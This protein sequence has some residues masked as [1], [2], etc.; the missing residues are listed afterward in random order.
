[1]SPKEIASGVFHLPVGIANVYFVG[2]SGGPWVLVDTAVPGRARQIRDAA[3]SVYGLEG[4]PESIVLTHGHMDHVG[5]AA[6][7]A[8]LWSV[9]IFVH[10]LEIPFVT[11]KAPYP[12]LDP[13][14]GGFLAMLGRFF[15]AP[16]FDLGHHVR[17]L[18]PDCAALGLLG[19]EWHHT[20]GHTPG[21]VV[22]FRREDGTLVAGDALTTV[23]LDSLIA[24]ATRKQRVWRPP[25]PSTA[26]WVAAAE[27]VKNLAE[28]W[29][30]TIACG[31]GRP[32]SGDSAVVQLA[33]LATNFPFPSHGRYVREPAWIDEEGTMHLPP[34]P[35]DPL[36]AVAVGLGI[37]AAA[38]T[39][40]A[41]A[42][43]RRNRRG[44]FE[45]GPVTADT[46][47]P[48]S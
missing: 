43:R 15:P 20:P 30:L 34:K 42:A 38:G 18:E 33:E 46:P 23:N 11:G 2:R 24:T 29:P 3:R 14:V 4:R 13:T 47:A 35:P 7:L 40:F 9:P 27:S 19:W 25:T 31:H 22:F 16:A 21:H 36:P 32:M 5:S 12:P 1:V 17:P 37:A 8:D 45:A 6:E 39:M 48:A 28:L 44:A 26:D 10:P 41:L